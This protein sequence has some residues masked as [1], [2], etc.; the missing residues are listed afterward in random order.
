[1]QNIRQPAHRYPVKVAWLAKWKGLIGFGLFFQAGVL[2]LLCLNFSSE[3]HDL[4]PEAFLLGLF[5]DR[6]KLS[7][8]CAQCLPESTLDRF[9]VVDS[10]ML[11]SYFC[12][13]LFV[14][15]ENMCSLNFFH[16]LVQLL[17]SIVEKQCFLLQLVVVKRVGDKFRLGCGVILKALNGS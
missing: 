10:L 6:L 5:H 4:L 15:F 16:F 12:N 7:L 2:L 11:I 9:L 1:V 17:I 8:P 3:L 14:V 13:H